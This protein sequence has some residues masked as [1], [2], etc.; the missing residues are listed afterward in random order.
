MAELRTHKDLTERG[1]STIV[2][3]L[4]PLGPGF[5]ILP[6]LIL[7]GSTWPEAADDLDVVVL[8]T[9]GMALLAYHHWQGVLEASPGPEWRLRFPGGGSEERPNPAISLKD[10]A[11]ALETYFR[12]RGVPPPQVVMALVFPDRTKIEGDP[13]APIQDTGRIADW[14]ASHLSSGTDLGWPRRAADQLRPPTPARLVNQ[15]Q[16][17]GIV[18]RHA[19]RTTFLAFDTLKNQP[20]LLREL[21]YDPYQQEEH[22]EKFRQELL[23]E[24]KLTM[25]LDHPNVV[26]IERVIPKDD[27]YYVV[28]EWIDSCQPL[29]ERLDLQAPFS[30][31]EAID[32]VTQLASAL[33]HAHGKGIVHRDVR[34]ENV[35]VA[36][37]TVK[38][39]NF[40][41]A[42]KADLGTRPTFDLRKMATE[43]PYAAPEFRLGQDGHHQVDGRADIFSLGVVLYEMLTGQLPSHLD[44]KYW[45]PPSQ[46]V[47]DLP[48]GLDEVVGKALK[49]DP[50]QRYSTMAA[51]RERL[52]H[53]RDRLQ[54]NAESPRLRYVDR[55]LVRRTRNSLIF[56]AEDRK[57]M[58]NV[59]LK[60]VVV[61]PAL[62]PEA[63]KQQLDAVLREV[64]IASQIIHPA[65]VHVMDHF[66]QD[67]DA[68]IVM[69]W[70]DGSSLRELMDTRGG[71]LS[72]DQG[73]DLVTAAG[74]ALHFAHGLGIIHRDMKP[75]NIMVQNGRATILDFGIATAPG[76]LL[77]EDTRAAGTARYIAPEVLRGQDIDERADVFSLGVVAY[78]ALTGRYPYAAPIIMARYSSGHLHEGVAAPSALNLEVNGAL[79]LTLLRA[80][81]PDPADRFATMADFLEA[82][83]EARGRRVRSGKGRKTAFWVGGIS[84]VALVVVLGAIALQP[85]LTRNPKQ[86]SALLSPEAT[87]S[88]DIFAQGSSESASAAI[89]V[90]ASAFQTPPPTPEPPPPDPT[91]P[92]R[93]SWASSPKDVGGVA[94]EILGVDPRNDGTFVTLR[95]RNATAD[96]VRLLTE[97]GMIQIVDSKG[98]DFSGSIDYA[99][100]DPG[101]KEVGA[102]QQVE[103]V[104]SFRQGVD[105]DTDALNLVLKEDGGA[106]RVWSL[107]A[108]RMVGP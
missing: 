38:I 53:V 103:G 49:F 16:L 100:I 96:V 93:V 51:F 97:E 29:R 12:D 50:A 55:K 66:V 25:E 76:Q 10:K 64:A 52:L 7:P 99:S 107:M 24:A 86:P 3:A 37:D 36:P 85:F 43:S 88:A 39:T 58:R 48:P 77:S 61:D 108:H 11:S 57:T 45:E 98:T 5:V 31:D 83:A 47:R 73:L 42:K 65:V 28:A 8:G 32:V 23:R 91:P 46:F 94:V 35:L 78:E 17:T 9:G 95:I 71:M 104:F 80:L 102:T 87:A 15:Y 82:I 21:P 34:P 4:L 106:G 13:G 81:A 2:G 40:G 1:E 74:E 105:P 44:E 60:K 68:Y 84:G 14:I 92:P 101:L 79:S 89:E 33:S 41:L 56:Q 62:G 63:R 72:V 27:R 67:D 30:P 70:L 26:R 75:E 22:L 59:A 18:K 20:V 69:E 54:D 6:H 90:V 19:D